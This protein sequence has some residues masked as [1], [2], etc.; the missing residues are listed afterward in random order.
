MSTVNS[1]KFHE[2]CLVIHLESNGHLNKIGWIIN[3]L[4]LNISND[5]WLE[6]PKKIKIKKT[7]VTKDII[8]LF[9]FPYIYLI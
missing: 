3:S 5:P 6:N 9:Y 2:I 7:M 4:R 1:Q 8:W